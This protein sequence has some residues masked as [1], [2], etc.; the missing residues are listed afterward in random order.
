MTDS[1]LNN[2][3]VDEEIILTDNLSQ[4]EKEIYKFLKALI[5]QTNDSDCP[6][7]IQKTSNDAKTQNPRISFYLNQ[8]LSSP[9]WFSL[10]YSKNKMN[11]ITGCR[12]ETVLTQA[13]INDSK[14][15][16]D[17]L[18]L[19]ENKAEKSDHTW[20]LINLDSN[21]LYFGV[22]QLSSILLSRFNFLY[23]H[24]LVEQCCCNEFEE[25]SDKK[26]C[27]CED[28]NMA[29]KCFYRKHLDHNEIFYGKNK[30]V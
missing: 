5:K 14:E 23:E 4:E 22:E 18:S 30:N 2:T 15:F 19:F 12:L 21:N 16:S 20:R 3:H 7:V 11:K 26:K 1:S 27:V 13:E 9:R 24:R 10:I 29:M 28:R 6:I 25:C 17:A 8:D